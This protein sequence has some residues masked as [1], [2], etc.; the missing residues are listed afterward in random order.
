[1][2]MAHLKKIVG[3]GAGGH[4]RAVADLIDEMGGFSVVGFTDA[5]PLHVK[6][7]PAP[8]LGDDQRLPRLLKDGVRYA[9]LGV[10]AVAAR[11][12]RLRA[13]MYDQ[14]VALGFHFP[15]LV[16]P[17]SFVSSRATLGKGTV[18]MAGA[19]VSAGARLGENVVIYSGAVVE[20]DV[21]IGNHS[22]LSPGTMIAG[23]VTLGEGVFVG[24]GAV[25][26]QGVSVGPW[27]TV[28][29]GA[30]VLTD[31]PA[32]RAVVGVPARIVKGEKA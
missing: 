2:T 24:I 4:G 6:G 32:G 14:I 28:G 21:V 3:I 11:G 31:V 5:D 18:V 25:V 20:H 13:R 26:I 7:S 22:H 1:M 17:K 12:L 10:G 9:F 15:L 16:H 27:S 8:V 29:A 23:G 30:V 19:V